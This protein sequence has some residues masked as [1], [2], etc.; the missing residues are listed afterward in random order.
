MEQTVT[1]LDKYQLLPSCT[2]CRK[3]CSEKLTEDQ[4]QT[5]NRMYWGS[6]FG[7]RRNFLD[8]YINIVHVKRRRGDTT[9]PDFRRTMSFWYTLPHSDGVKLTVC[10]QMFLH[11]LG[12]KT[13]GIVTEFVRAK[14]KA[15]VSTP[16]TKDNRG[17]NAPSNK[18]DREEV[19]KH[20]DSYHPQTSHYMREHAPHRR[21][22]DEHLSITGKSYY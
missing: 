9:A 8:S 16:L 22:L 6:T 4:R 3:K 14:L 21:Y 13:D 12:L 20:I 17:Q 11:T 2:G 18:I 15:D 10:K 19:R 5:I 7:E 1:H